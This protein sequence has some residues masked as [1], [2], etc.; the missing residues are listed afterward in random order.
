MAENINEEKLGAIQSEEFCY[1]AKIQNEFKKNEA[2]VPEKLRLKVGAQVIFCRNNIG[3]G[4]MNG[5]IGKVSEL[6]DDKI[7]VTL[8]SGKTIDVKEVTWDNVK[9]KYN[10]QTHKMETQVV[11]TFTQYPLK[12]AWAITIHRSQGMTFER[13]H[14][15]LS[16][17]TFL[18]GQA[19]VAISRLRS[20]DGLTLS[21][22]IRP[23]HVTQNQEGRVFA[24]SYNDTEMI[25]DVLGAEKR[26]YQY[27]STK[28]YDMASKTCLI[29]MQDKIRKNDYRN[30]ALMAKRMFDIMLDDNCLLGKTQNAQ[31]LK[32]CSMT[33][34][35]LNA[36]ICLYGNRYEEAEEKKA[37]DKKLLL[38]EARVNEH[39]GNPIAQF[40][41]ELFSLCPEFLS[42]YI[43]LRKVFQNSHIGIQYDK[44]EEHIE[45]IEAFNDK[46]LSQQ[47]V[48]SSTMHK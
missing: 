30:A 18:P 26:I 47:F 42:T 32:D 22:P 31:L 15:D 3:S 6:G 10:R 48:F 24:S 7:Q 34:N 8:E 4:Y 5:T 46:S 45:L 35:F 25:D 20:L 23:Y 16:H 43:M 44:E 29:L 27:L 33:A 37:I 14:F 13:M 36:V 17:G 11:G 28:D 1:Q 19:Y 9:S 41:K 2:P 39:I 38:F 21:N 40:C 12:L